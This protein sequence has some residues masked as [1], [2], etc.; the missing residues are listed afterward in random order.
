VTS[1]LNFAF[2]A[3]FLMAALPFYWLLIN[4]PSGDA[5]A[6]PLT[7]EQLREAADAIQGENPISI[8]YDTVSARLVPRIVL[9]A[10]QGIRSTS[11]E[12]RSYMLDFT[13]QPPVLIDPGTTLVEAS[14]FRFE[15]V[16]EEA[17]ERID[18]T[19]HEAG[20][21]LTLGDGG[22]RS[23]GTGVAHCTMPRPIAA[24]VVEIP[25][26]DHVLARRLVY[27][28]LEDAREF[29]LVGDIA[30]TMANILTMSGPSRFLNDY[31]V[32][33]D[34]TA[35]HSWLLTINRLKEQAPELE[36]IPGHDQLTRQQMRRSIDES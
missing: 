9:A 24:G 33:Q 5:A 20:L 13:G 21:V 27:V 34:R 14:G 31:F 36:I 8:R 7:I 19:R 12:M 18:K 2:F 1:R 16:E 32:T 11:V 4:D 26:C 30:P 23:E 29:L 35:I 3:L 15:G 28:R 25:V 6:K 17:L 10:G 22:D